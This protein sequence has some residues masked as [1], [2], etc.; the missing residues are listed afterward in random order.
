MAEPTE[1]TRSNSNFL[2]LGVI[3]ERLRAE[4]A[5]RGMSVAD[6]SRL[7]GLAYTTVNRILNSNSNT[8][9]M[10]NLAALSDAIGLDLSNLLG[11][12]PLEINTIP[13]IHNPT[14]QQI[15]RVILNQHHTENF[16]LIGSEYVDDCCYVS[17]H[18]DADFPTASISTSADA[19]GYHIK[20][21]DALRL[22]R[23][24]VIENKNSVYISTRLIS[25]EKLTHRSVVCLAETTN[26]TIERIQQQVETTTIIILDFK[27]NLT[28]PNNLISRYYWN[29]PETHTMQRV[30]PHDRNLLDH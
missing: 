10:V 19:I 9:T 30:A 3:S 11:P 5:N 15:R 16:N 12:G 24:H 21:T 1:K 2:R 7:S 28:R 26:T 20:Y 27:K 8:T 25:I 29:M 23:E 14:V 18:Y 22:N 4:A 17:P 13:G 6:I